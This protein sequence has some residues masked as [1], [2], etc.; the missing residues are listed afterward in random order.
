MMDNEQRRRR[1]CFRLSF[2]LLGF[3][4]CLPVVAFMEEDQ[5]RPLPPPLPPPLLPLSVAGC[6]FSSVF[7]IVIPNVHFSNHF[8]PSFF[9]SLVSTTEPTFPLPLVRLF[10][11]NDV[12]TIFNLLS[13]FAT[14][15]MAT[16]TTTTMMMMMMMSNCCFVQKFKTIKKSPIFSSNTK[17]LETF[18]FI[19]SFISF[20]SLS[21]STTKICLSFSSSRF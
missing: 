10:R 6:Y 21:S 4:P 2:S 5:A 1:Q 12:R 16:T 7:A 18:C 8:L 17:R 11:Y 9:R 13:F 15:T 14:T 19:P 20:I 3:L